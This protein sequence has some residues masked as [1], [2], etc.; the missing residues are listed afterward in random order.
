METLENEP[1]RGIL[2]ALQDEDQRARIIAT[3]CTV[4]IALLVY[5]A[6]VTI[7]AHW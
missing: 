7:V 2:R 1:P 3:G 5:C 4:I 6:V